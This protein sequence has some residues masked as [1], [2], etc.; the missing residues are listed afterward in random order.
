MKAWPAV[1]GVPAAGHVTARGSWHPGRVEGCA[2]CEPPRRRSTG[3]AVS[4]QANP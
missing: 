1:P 3:H 4:E 2:K